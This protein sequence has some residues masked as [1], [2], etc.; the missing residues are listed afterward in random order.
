MHLIALKPTMSWHS[1]T[2]CVVFLIILFNI[3]AAMKIVI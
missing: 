3:E 2:T 1:S